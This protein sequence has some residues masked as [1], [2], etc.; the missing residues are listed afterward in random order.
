MWQKSWYH[1]S[2]VGDGSWDNRTWESLPAPDAQEL[3]V[4]SC[5]SSQE[6]Q[7]TVEGSW[8]KAEVI[9]TV[10]KGVIYERAGQ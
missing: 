7:H 9:T 6:T 1:C 10:I 4:G 8:E 3:T 5:E 2:A